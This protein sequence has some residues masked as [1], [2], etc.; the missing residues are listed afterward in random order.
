MTMLYALFRLGPVL[1]LILI[2]LGTGGIKPCVSAFGGDQFTADQVKL[3]WIVG[4][5]SVGGS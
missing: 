3:A 4:L 5:F 1:G 2:G